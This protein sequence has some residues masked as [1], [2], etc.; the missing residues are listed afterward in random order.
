MKIK[1]VLSSGAEVLLEV[2][3]YSSF[4]NFIAAKLASG[5]III[6]ESAYNMSRVEAI[7]EI[8]DD[9]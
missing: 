6:D 3:G 8:K 1:V 7:H 5:W 9:K 4:R 2:D